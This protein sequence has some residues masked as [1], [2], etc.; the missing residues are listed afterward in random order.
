MKMKFVTL[1]VATLCTLAV[2]VSTPSLALTCKSKAVA[3]VLKTQ[4]NGIVPAH[5]QVVFKWSEKVREN[6]AYGYADWGF[7][8]NKILKCVK[9]GTSAFTV[10]CRARAVPCLAAI[11]D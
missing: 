10:E 6:N 7:A 5:Q 9:S 2:A 4:S 8:K 11:A 1:S 3:V